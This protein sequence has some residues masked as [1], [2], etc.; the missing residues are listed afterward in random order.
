MGTRFKG[1]KEEILALDAYIKLMRASES[2]TV[3]TGKVISANKLTVSQFGVLEAL[4]HLGSMC[5]NELGKKLLKSGGNITMVIGNLEKI[6]YVERVREKMDRRFITVS[7]TGKGRAKIA[8][9]FPQQ[10]SLITQEM[11]ALSA[12]EQIIFCK[13][14]KKLGLNTSEKKV[15]KK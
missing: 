15:G 3:R 14:C 5:Q 4:Y 1:K 8:E 7:L 6:G 10:V 12:K 2:I 9:I 11:S 13:L